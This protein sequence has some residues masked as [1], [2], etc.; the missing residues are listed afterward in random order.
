MTT[1]PV[2]VAHRG[3]AAQCPE[4]TLPALQ[5]AVAA[6]A[7]WVEVDV[8]LCAGGVPVLLHDADLQRIAARPEQVFD[9]DAATLDQI[10]AGE[11]QRFGDRFADAR[12][13]RL[14]DFAAWLRGHPEV[15]AFV[16]LKEESLERFGRA[17]VLSACLEALAPA[18][19]Q[20]ALIS[21]DYAV[22]EL[23]RA[24]TGAELGWVVRGYDA[25]IAARSRALPA[26]WLFCRYQRLPPGPLP[27]GPWDWVLYE[28]ADPAAARELIARGARWLETM[29][30]A[31]LA[32]ALAR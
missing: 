26:R 16:E 7:R 6:G 28:V 17:T 19:G 29:H 3:H 1:Q 30:C 11:P 27:E 12:I 25:D 13:L 5:S 32:A 21:D 2:L 31:E 15:Q 9:L 18:A 20:W 10:P 23:A 24:A 14:A 8:Q 22:L 4:N